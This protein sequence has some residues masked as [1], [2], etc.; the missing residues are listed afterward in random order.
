MVYF[1]RSACE[2]QH[3]HGYKDKQNLNRGISLYF[4]QISAYR[5]PRCLNIKFFNILS[6]VKS[7][8]NAAKTGLILKN[9]KN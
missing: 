5:G 2:F 9:V 7:S 4:D 6:I 1:R 8:L 3:G